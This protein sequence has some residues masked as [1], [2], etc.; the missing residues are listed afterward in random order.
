MF[1]VTHEV[2]ASLFVKQVIPILKG[3]KQEEIRHDRL[4]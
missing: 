3:E 2:C 4:D 1:S